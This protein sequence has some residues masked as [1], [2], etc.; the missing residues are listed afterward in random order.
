MDVAPN[1]SPMRTL[2]ITWEDHRRTRELCD[3][4]QLP[5]HV[6]AF[7][8]NRWMRYIRLGLSTVQL[9]L[10][11]RPAVLFLQT[12]SVALAMIAV[13]LRPFCGRYRIIMDAHNEAVTPYTYTQWPVPQLHRFTIR[14]AD[15]TI[16]TNPA[17]VAVIDKIGGQ[18]FVLPDRLPATPIEHASFPEAL[19]PFRV[20]VVATYA[21]DEPIA[22]I[23]EAARLLG[24]EYEFRITGRETKL[25]AEQR[26]RL[27]RNVIQTGFLSE[28]DYWVLMNE[29]HAVL[30]F[31]LKPNCLVC[32]AYEGLALLRP[33]IL[34]DNEATV[35]LFGRVAV[36][37]ASHTAKAIA[38]A[39][40]AC[41]GRH[42]ELVRAAADEKPRFARNW[43]EQAVHLKKLISDWGRGNSSSATLRRQ[44]AQS[45]T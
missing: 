19:T 18:A 28:H 17:L 6:L 14:S 27:P 5:L 35:A 36:F 26:A 12:P 39:V 9:L 8:G 37:P 25:P 44:R 1:A 34:S 22:E 20:M 3:G 33:M 16:V 7:G 23:I 24:S 13:L 21:A 10:R 40:R 42:G 15:L 29:N 45:R 11:A 2:A 31:T 30:D 41:R 43:D 4:L 38:E 32:G